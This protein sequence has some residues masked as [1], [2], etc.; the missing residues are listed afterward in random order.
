ME[1]FEKNE[2]KEVARE[3]WEALSEVLPKGKEIKVGNERYVKKQV[4]SEMEEFLLEIEAFKK[5]MQEL[6]FAYKEVA[7]LTKEFIKARVLEL[8]KYNIFQA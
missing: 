2:L 6:D 3:A 1:K 8:P 7:D 5:K 4:S